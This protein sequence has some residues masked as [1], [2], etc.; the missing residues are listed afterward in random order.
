MRSATGT[1]RRRCGTAGAPLGYGRPAPGPVAGPLP[2][3]MI[4]TLKLVDDP[5]EGALHRASDAPLGDEVIDDPARPGARTLRRAA[6]LLPLVRSEDAWHLL[7][8]RRAT[9][10]RDRHSGQVAFPGGAREPGD[11]S[12]VAAALREAREEIGLDPGRVTVLGT[13]GA[14]LTISRY[15]VVPVVGHVDWPA[16]LALEPREVARTFLMPLRWLGD[17]RNLTL[18]ARREMDP[19]SARHHP[20]VVYE[21]YDGEVLWGATARIAL[22]FLKALD[23]G[24]IRLPD[25]A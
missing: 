6:V 11:G 10:E 25:A 12:D 8:I 2:T 5:V 22:N 24:E 21:P 13:L 20:V 1:D 14:Y 9:D 4:R 15:E 17:R 3:P 19:A 7:F 23:E 16:P 18:R